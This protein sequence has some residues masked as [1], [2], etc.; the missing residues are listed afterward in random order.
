MRCQSFSMNFS[1]IEINSLK[2]TEFVNSY[3]LG[4]MLEGLGRDLNEW[5]PILVEERDHYI[6]D[7]HHRVQLAKILKEKKIKAYLVSYRDDRLKV[8]DYTSGKLLNK[9]DLL[10]KYEAGMKLPVKST[11]HIMD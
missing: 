1:L 10:K 9:D 8:Y 6:L 2:Q 7:G 3:Q 11:R 4:K 5:P